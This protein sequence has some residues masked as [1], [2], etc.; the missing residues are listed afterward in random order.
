[1]KQAKALITLA[2]TDGGSYVVEDFSIVTKDDVFNYTGTI[3]SVYGANEYDYLIIAIQNVL[4]NN[5]YY[6]KGYDWFG[7][8]MLDVYIRYRNERGYSRIP[9]HPCGAKCWKVVK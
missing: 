4:K 6:V 8:T 1:M 7:T 2:T 9:A 5:D 3:K